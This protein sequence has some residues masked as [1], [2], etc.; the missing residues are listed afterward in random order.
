LLIARDALGV[1]G[2]EVLD[3]IRIQKGMFFVSQRGPKR[4]IYK[5]RPYNWGPFSS[6]LYG[7]LDFLVATGALT[8][9][10]VP[11]RTWDRFRV[12]EVGLERAR[13]L[14]ASL[15]QQEVA[16]LG[17]LRRFLTTRSFD[18][19]LDDVYEAFP[20]YATESLYRR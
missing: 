2:P 3:P 5:F 4:D 20:E 19:L 11:G 17:Q 13:A 15:H 12:T 1:E 7:D 14:A 6:D 18:K 9:E 8:R 16:W 10:H